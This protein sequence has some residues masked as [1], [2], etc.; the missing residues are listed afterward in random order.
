MEISDLVEDFKETFKECKGKINDYLYAPYANHVDAKK[1]GI[2]RKAAFVLLGVGALWTYAVVKH[3]INQ[4]NLKKEFQQEMQDRLELNK[5]PTVY[6][7]GI[8]YYPSQRA[9]T[10]RAKDPNELEKSKLDNEMKEIYR[11]LTIK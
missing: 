11:I 8:P 4:Y 6:I 3:T 7:N 9:T 1:K 10:I 5:S 2:R